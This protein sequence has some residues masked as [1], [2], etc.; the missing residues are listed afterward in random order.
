MIR[1]WP[2]LSSIRE[3]G[4]KFVG[5]EPMAGVAMAPMDD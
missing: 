4:G 2:N 5:S 1:Q 3:G